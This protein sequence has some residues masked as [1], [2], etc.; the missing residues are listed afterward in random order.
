MK[1]AIRWYDYITIN[2]YYLGLTTLSQT[3]GLVVPL[4]V[5]QFVGEADKGRF[6]GNLRLWTLMVALLVQA[7][8]GLL[9]DNSTLKWGRRR[10][11]ILIGTL[12]DLVFIALMGVSIGMEGMSGY[13]FL[14]LIII[15]LQVSSNTAQGAQQGLIPDLIP[16]EKRGQFSGIKAAMEVPIPIILVAFTVATLVGKGNIW[17]GLLVA[18]GVLFITMLLT[19][20]VPETPLEERPGTLDWTPIVRLLAMTGLFTIVILGL[21]EGVKLIGQMIEGLE[22]PTGLAIIMVVSGA[23][24][25][26]L[27]VALGVWG[28]VRISLGEPA[29]KNPAFT[30]WVVNRL[31]FLVGVTNLSTFAVYFLQG[32]LGYVR[33]EAA[34]PAA[35]L[36]MVVGVFILIAAIPSGWLADRLGHKRLVT[37]SG[38]LA[39]VGTLIVILVP[40]MRIIYLGGFFIGLGTGIFYTANWALGTSLVP[41]EEA[42]RY[43]GISNLA[44]AGAGAIGAYIGGPIADYFT[45]RAPEAAGLGYVLLFAI[46]G[47]MFVFSLI[48]LTRVKYNQSVS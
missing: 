8:M 21:G 44:G 33:E 38:I 43:L 27:A 29:R 45:V 20:V 39:A 10:P 19:M 3:N 41:K 47:L 12:F 4:L 37:L 16:E 46:Y 6:F 7:G 40:D 31:A 34:Q 28:S 18:M 2:I 5:Q 25:M 17:G 30:W 23:I 35:N 32:R 15:L 13:W 1:R 9:S 11:F 42:G 22:S 24:A 36:M 26:I 48:A 14:F